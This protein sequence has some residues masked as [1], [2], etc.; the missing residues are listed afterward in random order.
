MLVW[1]IQKISKSGV[2]FLLIMIQGLGLCAELKI[3]SGNGSRPATIELCAQFQRVTGHRIV[4]EFYVNPTV[5]SKIEAGEYFDVA[6]LNP[7][8]LD[9][10]IGMGKIDSSSRVTMGRIGLGVAI[11]KGSPRPD[12]ST[13]QA[14]KKT[15][16]QAKSV[17]YPGDG[18]S[19]KYFVTL[20]DQL[21]ISQEMAT[22]MR[23]M[24]GEYNVEGVANG[25]VEM[26][27]VVASR[28]YGVDGVDYVGLIPQELQTWIGFAAGVSEHSKEKE[29]ARNFVKFISSQEAAKVMIPIGIEPFV[30]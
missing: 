6:V 18:A 29:V 19:G 15:L 3:L 4:L 16:L 1:I 11:R 21:G 22:K 14:F 23:P 7:P 26:I 27:V 30:E 25:Q 10:L 5:K 8:V 20:I 24:S 13:V 12:I 2:F 28:I 17:A 9:A